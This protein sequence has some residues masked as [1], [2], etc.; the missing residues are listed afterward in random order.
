MDDYG[1]RMTGLTREDALVVY[2]W[3]LIMVVYDEA[4]VGRRLVV[5]RELAVRFSHPG[6]N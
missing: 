5:S 6:G 2:G 3:A 4:L 1:W